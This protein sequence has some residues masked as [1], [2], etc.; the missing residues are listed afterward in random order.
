MSLCLN[1][2]ILCALRGLETDICFGYSELL[3]LSHVLVW[4]NTAQCN[5]PSAK[6]AKL[7]ASDSF[8]WQKCGHKPIAI[9]ALLH[10]KAQWTSSG[11]WLSLVDICRVVDTVND[12][13]FGTSSMC[14]WFMGFQIQKSVL[15]STIK[16]RKYG[17]ERFISWWRTGPWGNRWLWTAQIYSC[18]GGFAPESK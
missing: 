13:L 8:V 2:S 1:L 5:A 12:I 4:S 15:P 3:A 18:I 9:S 16:S 10:K 6:S 17:S 14:S 11:W 7:D